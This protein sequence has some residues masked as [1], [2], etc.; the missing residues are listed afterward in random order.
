MVLEMFTGYQR[1]N[2][3]MLGLFPS[4]TVGNYSGK[5]SEIQKA[6]LNL[7]AEN[8]RLAMDGG[9][10][11]EDLLKDVRMAISQLKIEATKQKVIINNQSEVHISPRTRTGAFNSSEVTEGLSS[12]LS[13]LADQIDVTASGQALLNSL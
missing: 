7:I 6:L 1:A 3:V 8:E 13:S 12:K 4:L 11:L 9:N 2:L 5:S 10:K